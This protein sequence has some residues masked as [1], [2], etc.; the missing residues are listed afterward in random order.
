MKIKVSE[1]TGPALDW[2]VAKC[3]G[4][5]WLFEVGG[6]GS[7]P[8]ASYSTDWSQGGPIIEREKIELGYIS[9][10]LDESQGWYSNK[11]SRGLD[12]VP[13]AAAGDSF[14]AFG[15]GPTPLIAAMRLRRWLR[16]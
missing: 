11:Y 7:P 3:D 4:M 9:Y 13:G 8:G 2:L 15:D 6:V 1:A 10:V 16:R 12:A 14:E 5:Q